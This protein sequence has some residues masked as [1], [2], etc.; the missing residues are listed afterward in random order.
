[1][2]A[3]N[4]RNGRCLGLGRSRALKGGGHFAVLLIFMTGLFTD[5]LPVR[6]LASFISEGDLSRLATDP[7]QTSIFG[8]IVYIYSVCKK[9]APNA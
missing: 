2:S 4:F 6:A 9:I 5:I 8:E 3:A 7:F 1:M